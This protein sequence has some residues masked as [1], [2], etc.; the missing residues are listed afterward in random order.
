MWAAILGLFPTVAGWINMLIGVFQKRAADQS[1]AGAAEQSAESDHQND[2]AQ[3]VAN[4]ASADAQNL[5]LDQIKQSLENPIPITVQTLNQ[6][7]KP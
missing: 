1:A 5:A 6:E 3:S 7:N 4:K 2:G